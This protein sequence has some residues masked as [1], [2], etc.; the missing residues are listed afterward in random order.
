LGGESDRPAIQL[1]PGNQLDPEM[2]STISP[3]GGRIRS[4]CRPTF[5]RKSTGS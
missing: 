4:S 1:P 2:W 5:A 3:A